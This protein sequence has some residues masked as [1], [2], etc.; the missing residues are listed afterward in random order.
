M[1]SWSRGRTAAL[2]SLVLCVPL[3]AAPAL[4]GPAGAAPTAVSSAS[5][6]I[7]PR[8]YVGGQ[9]ITFA[10]DLGVA[11]KRRI[12][13]QVNL[14]RPG[15]TWKDVKGFKRRTTRADGT[16]RFRYLAPSMFGIRMRVASGGLHTPAQEFHALS[17]DLV[18]GLRTGVTGLDPGQVVVDRP[19][20]LTVD[21][22]PEAVRDLARR[23]DLPPPVFPGRALTLQRRQGGSWVDVATDAVTT[24]AQGRGTFEGLVLGTAGQT[25]VYRAVQEAWTQDNSRVGWYPS[26]PVYLDVVA[27]ARTARAVATGSLATLTATESDPVTRESGTPLQVARDVASKTAAERY[28]WRPSLWDFGWTYG[29]SLTDRPSRGADR[30]GWWEEWSDGTGR[31][32]KHNGGL[33]LDSQRQNKDGYGASVGTTMVTMRGNPRAR[34]RWEV[35]LRM[36]S[37]ETTHQDLR[38]LIELVPADATAGCRAT[39][40]TVAEASPHQKGIT[41]GARNQ[42]GDEWKRTEGGISVN[43]TSHAVAVEVTD[44]HISWFLEGRLIGTVTSKAAIPDVPLTLRLSLQGKGQQQVNRTQ[45]IFDWMR[46]YG[47]DRGEQVDG[48]PSLAKGSHDLYC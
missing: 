3:L 39:G 29:E 9:R 22:T 35:R 31:S 15:D 47:L 6:Q 38:A 26:F 11:G 7:S 41:I 17:Q 8:E 30:T 16:F 25:V 45:A 13:L 14:S 2:S 20:D 28:G 48:G 33:M 43:G 46:G 32:A 44:R 27:S 40:I 4:V 34:G 10:G 5:L 1:S 36:K 42:A 12:K 19:F 21:T 18:V 24:D 37:T 23:T